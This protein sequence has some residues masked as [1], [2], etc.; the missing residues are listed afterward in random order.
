LFTT[1]LGT[2]IADWDDNHK[3]R[4]FHSL[5]RI[6]AA[7][8]A[9]GAGSPR[10][11]ISAGWESTVI[12]GIEIIN[13]AYREQREADVAQRSGPLEAVSGIVEGIKGKVKEVI[14][15]VTRNDRLGREA[16][17]Q[18]DK[19]EAQR[20]AAKREAEAESARASAKAAEA[21]QK[22]NQ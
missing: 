18:Q 13:A 4:H 15:V 16:R 10:F 8:S 5:P 3:A 20:N 21:R 9:T 12:G 22:G 6:Q 19:G 2:V 1:S 11:P 7:R 17:A 14:S